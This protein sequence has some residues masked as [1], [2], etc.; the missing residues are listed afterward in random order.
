MVGRQALHVL[1]ITEPTLQL[2]HSHLYCKQ[3][4]LSKQHSVYPNN[5][6]LATKSPNLSALVTARL[7]GTPSLPFLWCVSG[8]PRYIECR[9]N[10][11]PHSTVLVKV[12]VNG[13]LVAVQYQ[14]SSRGEWLQT[15]F[16]VTQMLT[17]YPKYKRFQSHISLP[18][19][20]R[21]L[22]LLLHVIGASHVLQ[23]KIQNCV[24]LCE[25]IEISRLLKPFKSNNA[26]IL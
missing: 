17:G 2:E 16:C 26:I 9:Q 24:K 18:I 8:R 21:R 7:L 6:A 12:R 25:L 13:H 5:P 14:H 20:E 19:T 10:G 15:T 1:R 11:T 3:R 4:T 22:L 23:T